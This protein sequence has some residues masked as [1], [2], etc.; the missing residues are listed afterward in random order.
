[1]LNIKKTAD[2]LRAKVKEVNQDFFKVSN[3]IVEDTIVAGE[4]W[5]NV[6]GDALKTGT[7]VLNTQQKLA[8]KAVAGMREQYMEGS[9][10][11]MQ[12]VGIDPKELANKVKENAEEAK[13]KVNKAT[14]T[15][16]TRA[17]KMIEKTTTEARQVVARANAAT[18]DKGKASNKIRK[19][20][21]SMKAEVAEV[22]AETNEVA[23]KVAKAV[24]P[25]VKRDNLKLI[26][27]IGP[28]MEEVLNKYGIQTFADLAAVDVKVLSEQLEAESARYAGYDVEEWK[29][30]AKKLAK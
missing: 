19:A 16:K 10:R 29:K 22:V 4:Q 23:E 13:A 30:E 5:Q 18:D 3:E 7:Q 20:E 8:M 2:N 11:F 25:S 27:R 24:A 17:N 9:E 6:F 14:T 21:K 1:M 15:A 28:K 26:N 12:L